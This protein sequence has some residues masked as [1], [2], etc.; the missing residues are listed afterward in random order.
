MFRVPRPGIR[1]GS[2]LGAEYTQGGHRSLGAD[3]HLMTH[4]GQ[5]SRSVTAGGDE[6]RRGGTLPEWIGTI[7]FF[8]AVGLTAAKLNS[9]FGDKGILGYAMLM[10]MIV[11]YAAAV[12][13]AYV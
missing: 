1:P 3:H 2:A 8:A 11:I 10:M 5:S 7:L 13:F 9:D 4:S 12:G 6:R